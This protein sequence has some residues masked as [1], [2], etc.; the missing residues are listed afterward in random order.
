MEQPHLV[1]K[2]FILVKITYNVEDGDKYDP[3]GVTMLV[4]LFALCG[5]DT[6]A[7]PDGKFGVD[8]GVYLNGDRIFDVDAEVRPNWTGLAFPFDPIHVVPRKM[9]KKFARP[10]F[11]ATID[12]SGTRA[13]L[14]DK[15]DVVKVPGMPNKRSQGEVEEFF[16]Y[17]QADNRH[18]YFD[19]FDNST[20]KLNL[21]KLIERAKRLD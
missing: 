13:M 12:N 3:L 2:E 7:Y 19:I 14:I 16:G 1:R 9:A 18:F 20:C 17:Y 4:S 6:I 10:V 15:R 5:L 21:D 11:F 8:V